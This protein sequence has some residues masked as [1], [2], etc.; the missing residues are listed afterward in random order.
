M[1]E[2]DERLGMGVV[3]SGVAGRYRSLGDGQRQFVG[4]LLPGDLLYFGA[5]SERVDCGVKAFGSTVVARGSAQEFM[6]LS[7]QN[8]G[9]ALGLWKAI[10]Q[11]LSISREWTL[12]VGRRNAEQR[13]AH[14]I[15][16]QYTRLS[17]IGAAENNRFVMPITQRDIADSAGLTTVHVNR[18]LQRLKRDELVRI[19]N[20]VCTIQDWAALAD[21]AKFD[22][23][24][25]HLSRSA[26]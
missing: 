2:H 9:I 25:L 11:D 12:N 1:R 24:Y 26:L 23:F 4:Y 3:L 6:A 8:A 17:A 15:C 18:V 22:P 13:I 20:G 21:R 10:I 19:E 16:E 5:L 7:A 14:L